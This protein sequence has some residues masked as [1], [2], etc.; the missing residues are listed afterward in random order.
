[1]KVRTLILQ[2]KFQED[3]SPCPPCPQPPGPRAQRH[4]RLSSLEAA[5]VESLGQEVY[6]DG[7]QERPPIGKQ[8]G[9]GWAERKGD[10][11][12]QLLLRPRG[13]LELDT[14]SELPQTE[15]RGGP[16]YSHISQSLDT[17]S[18]QRRHNLRRG[19]SQCQGN[20]RGRMQGYSQLP[21]G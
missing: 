13:A 18:R 21:W 5:E 3:A 9:Q 17:G 12:V 10:P 11:P 6:A 20:S 15:V 14:P 16:L 8:E 2:Q 1:M 7:S 19:A 4:L